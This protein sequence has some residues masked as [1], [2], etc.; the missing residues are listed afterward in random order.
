MFL[1]HITCLLVAGCSANAWKF[2]TLVIGWWCVCITGRTSPTQALSPDIV[3]DAQYNLVTLVMSRD[4]TVFEYCLF[5]QYSFRLF[6]PPCIIKTRRVQK[7]VVL[8]NQH[9]QTK[10]THIHS[11]KTPPPFP[12]CACE[13]VVFSSLSPKYVAPNNISPS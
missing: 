11:K 6:I 7:V 10:V 5:C 1:G 2:T 4:L 8:I 12:V 9:T 3:K 13:C